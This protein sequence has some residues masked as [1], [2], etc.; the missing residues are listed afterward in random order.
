MPVLTG[1]KTIGEKAISVVSD[2]GLIALG[3]FAGRYVAEKLPVAQAMGKAGLEVAFGLAIILA[4]QYTGRDGVSK[5]GIGIG[6]DGIAKVLEEII[7]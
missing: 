3:S 5:F 1:V 2:V 4:G 6:A 7:P